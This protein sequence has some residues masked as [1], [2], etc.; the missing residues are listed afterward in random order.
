[1][2]LQKT[3]SA[4][5]WKTFLLQSMGYQLVFLQSLEHKD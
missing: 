5:L 2:A 3:Y 1:M 4:V